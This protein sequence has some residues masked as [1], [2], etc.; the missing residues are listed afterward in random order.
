ML[1]AFS[2][3]LAQMPEKRFQRV[4]WLSLGLTLLVFVGVLALA[5][6]VVLPMLTVFDAGWLN[7]LV[8]AAGIGVMLVALFVLFPSIATF[9]VCFFLDS[10]AE[11]VED[12]YYPTDPKGRDVPL[13]QALWQT[14]KLVVV[15]VV[16][17]ILCLPLYLVPGLNL[18]VFYALN[19]YLLSREYFELVSIRHM[20][21]SEA[22]VLRR[23]AGLTVFVT[24]VVIAFLLTVPVVNLVA[25]VFA[26]AA[27]VHVFKAARRRHGADLPA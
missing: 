4:L 6:Y 12:R 11:A 22:S 24:G 10:I 16:L 20:T 9:F 8:E 25:P 17:N 21:P 7:W 27:M 1:S 15:I 2:K 13:G 5:N 3:A 14:L 26:T 18:F 23:R 19:G